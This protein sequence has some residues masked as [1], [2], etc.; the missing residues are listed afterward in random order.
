MNLIE[1]PRE[2]GY[3]LSSLVTEGNYR[4]GSLPAKLLVPPN[5]DEVAVLVQEFSVASWK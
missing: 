1:A 3:V 5:R 2:R 4:G